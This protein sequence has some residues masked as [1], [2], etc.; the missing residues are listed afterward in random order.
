MEATE[1]EHA[2][3]SSLIPGEATAVAKGDH[4]PPLL[5]G[6]YLLPRG[7]QIGFIVALA[8]TVAVAVAVLL[9]AQQKDYE[10]LFVNLPEKEAGEIVEALKKLDTDFEIERST[11]AVLVPAD[12]VHELRLKLATQGLPRQGEMGFD[13]LSKGSS[14]GTSQMMEGVRFQHALEGE[15]ARSVMTIRG[16]K[17]ARV[18]L[19]LPKESVFI[20]Q[21]RKA[22]ASVV[23]ELGSGYGLE[24]GQVEGIVH[25][26]AA[27]VP[28]LEPS[29]V[30]VVDGRGHLLNSTDSSS[31]MNLTAKQFDYKRQ[32]EDHLIERVENILSPVVGHEGMRTQ[33]TVDLDFTETERT[34]E[35]YNPDLPALRSEQ[36]AE[37]QNR[38]GAVPQG[39]PGAL[40]NQPP[41]AGVAPETT[42]QPGQPGEPAAGAGASAAAQPS[43]NSKSATRNYEL[44]KTIS[45]S[46]LGTGQVRRLTVAVVVDHLRVLQPDGSYTSQPYSDEDL[47]RFSSL[48]KEAVGYDATRG[49][50]VT[51]TNAAFKVEEAGP[52][53]PLW[54]L[55]WFWTLAKQIGAGLVLILLIF[56]VLRPAVRG[57]LSR[58]AAERGTAAA[59]AGAAGLPGAEPGAAVASLEGPE[60]ESIGALEG[61]DDV[62]L[63][64]A[65]QSYEKR[66]EFA[67]RA[68][69]NDPK[70]VAQVIKIWMTG[71]QANG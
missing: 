16:V 62:L 3:G 36:V 50:R 55:P 18:H 24:P 51:V 10:R 8:L 69:D 32:F 20:R 12:K 63:L 28:Q 40:T 48:V 23:V 52:P 15:I 56:G 49:D 25:L 67:Q 46:R 21:P 14:F 17:S 70:R 31:G 43:S 30:T 61:P 58:E 45:H 1:T 59:G 2:V 54:E 34:Q 65:P 19:A 64:E 11:G 9:W 6:F 35:L 68:I 13:A 39:V 42:G 53:A 27:S 38:G 22:S 71:E 66:L 33:A 44:D 57:L 29:Q 37:E 26:V 41:P 47:G 4:L 5:R 60:G 7:R